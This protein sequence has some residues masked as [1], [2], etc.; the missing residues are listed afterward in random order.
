MSAPRTAVVLVS[1]GLDSCVA[2]AAAGR[3]HDLAFLHISYG[4]RTER[5]E[6]AAFEH[7]AEHFSVEKMCR[8][9]ESLYVALAKRAATEP[10]G[11][12]HRDHGEA[13]RRG[14]S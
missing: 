4:Q 13:S 14:L 10:S 7:I 2:A 11:P 8:E 6:R 12:N 5:R 3:D 1:G 9:T